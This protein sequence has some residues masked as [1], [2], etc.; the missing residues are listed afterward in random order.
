VLLW[1]SGLFWAAWCLP[2]SLLGWPLVGNP[3]LSWNA[4]IYG[5]YASQLLLLTRRVG[6]FRWINLVFPVPVL[7]FLG[8]FLLAIVNLER[9][10]VRWK[11][12]TFRT[13]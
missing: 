2:A 7:F 11:G 8:V 3:A 13:R 10:Q 12:R 1:L 9:G 5:A 6:R 4:L